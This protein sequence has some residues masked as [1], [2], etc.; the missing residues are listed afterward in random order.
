MRHAL[1]LLALLIAAFLGG[2]TAA[3]RESAPPADLTGSAQK[4]QP[5]PS[6]ASFQPVTSH[7]DEKIQ[8]LERRVREQDK[9]IAVL[10]GQL[11]TFKH[12]E[13]DVSTKKKQKRPTVEGF[14]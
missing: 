13:L 7:Q 4:N 10:R 11:E 1:C 8:A 6:T 14:R 3:G 2:C 5:P 12:I 9:E